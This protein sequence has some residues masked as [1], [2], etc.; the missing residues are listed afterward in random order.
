MRPICRSHTCYASC[1]RQTIQQSNGLVNRILTLRI[2]IYVPRRSSI[3]TMHTIRRREKYIAWYDD[4]VDDPSLLKNPFAQIPI[5]N[6]K[7]A[8]ISRRAPTLVG[9]SA[10]SKETDHPERS[11]SGL[12]PA[13][14]PTEKRVEKTNDSIDIESTSDIEYPL[15]R[16]LPSLVT[17]YLNVIGRVF[18]PAGASEK[19]S[20][21]S[22]QRALQAAETAFK[23]R[24]KSQAILAELTFVNVTQDSSSINDD[25]SAQG[26][27]KTQ[28]AISSIQPAK[29]IDLEAIRVSH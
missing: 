17:T 23:N 29:N 4:P 24:V 10:H 1:P 21:T 28:V 14:G 16:R 18:Q 15:R 8:A 19:Q 5:N 9:V 3:V 27:D 25:L 7:L 26:L 2:G 6:S 20:A 22:S 13:S 12:P 11:A